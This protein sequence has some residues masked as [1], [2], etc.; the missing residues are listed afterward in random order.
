MHMHTH[1]RTHTC[2][3]TCTCTH[4]CTRTHARTLRLLVL[5]ALRKLIFDLPS[6]W[7]GWRL[8]SNCSL[9][10]QTPGKWV[11]SVLGFPRRA[12]RGRGRAVCGQTQLSSCG[13]TVS[14]SAAPL[15]EAHPSVA[16]SLT[17]AGSGANAQEAE[18]TGRQNNCFAWWHK[19]IYL[20]FEDTGAA[21]HLCLEDSGAQNS[22]TCCK[23]AAPG[24]RSQNS[25]QTAWGALDS[26][27]SG[28]RANTHPQARSI[29]SNRKGLFSFVL[30]LIKCF[31]KSTEAGETP[32]DVIYT[33]FIP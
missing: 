17:T 7:T 24:S 18:S 33:Q 12:V 21:L 31:D 15:N 14:A 32:T 8:K 28:L 10:L 6:R 29:A 25:S 4:T 5:S 2:A 9:L 3:H 1:V 26:R 16:A 19:D 23:E 11:V 13:S 20:S 22:Q 30:S 27:D